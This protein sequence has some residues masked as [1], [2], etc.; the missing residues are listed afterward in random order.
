MINTVAVLL[1]N[2]PSATVMRQIAEQREV[3]RGV[4]HDVEQ[5]VGDQVR[6]A[7]R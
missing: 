5:P 4:A 1:M 7:G 2:W 6:G 3:G